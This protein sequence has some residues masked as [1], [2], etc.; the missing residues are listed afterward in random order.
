MGN[1]GLGRDAAAEELARKHIIGHLVSVMKHY[2]LM[3]EHWKKAKG[4]ERYAD[5]AVALREIG[6][7]GVAEIYLAAQLY[8]TPGQI[9]EKLEERHAVFGDF[10]LIPYLPLCGPVPQVRCG[11]S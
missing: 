11:V 10:G 2:D 1:P 5:R 9:L 8:G 4:Y 3:G 6:L 7:E